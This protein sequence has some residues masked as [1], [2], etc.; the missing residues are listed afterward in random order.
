M[1]NCGICS[2]PIGP[3]VRAKRVVIER[4]DV[5][6]PHRARANPK[7]KRGGGGSKGDDDSSGYRADPGGTGWEIVREIDACGRC[8]ESKAT[9]GSA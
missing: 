3:R 8:A 2:T 4:R 1:F 7:R 6:Y 9:S 5:V